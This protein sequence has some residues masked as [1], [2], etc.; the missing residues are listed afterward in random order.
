MK[1]RSVFK[2]LLAAPAL[3]PAAAAQTPPA[4]NAP[5]ADDIFKID[6]TVPDAAADPRHK[7]FSPQQYATLGRLCDLFG[8][9]YAGKPSARQAE[10]PQFLDFLLAQSPTDRQVLYSQGLDQLDINARHS[11]GKGFA[12]LADGDAGALLAP[13]R[14][15]WTWKAPADPL[16]HFLRDAKMDILRATLN[17]KVYADAAAAGSRRAAGLNT[18]W[19]V[20]E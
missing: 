4:S 15:P 9:A 14:A 1:R 19:D 20:I 17:S 16:A 11:L 5:V 2:S 12:D 13:L 18:Y 6:L 7:F 8:P 3:A 10:V